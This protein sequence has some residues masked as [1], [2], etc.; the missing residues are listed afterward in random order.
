MIKGALLVDVYK[1]FRFSMLVEGES[2]EWELSDFDE[3]F[4]IVGYLVSCCD[5]LWELSFVH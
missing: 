1:I 2:V 5:L 4:D 3:I